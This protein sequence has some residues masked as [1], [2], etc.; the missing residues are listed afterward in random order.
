LP[1]A[2]IIQKFFEIRNE[3]YKNITTK[4]NQILL[5]TNLRD[6]LFP[7]LI[8]GQLRIADAEAEIEKVSA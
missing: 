2:E 5:L 8:S 7:H 3:I 6:I 4:E 1:A